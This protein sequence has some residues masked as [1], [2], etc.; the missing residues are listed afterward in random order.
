MPLAS[1]IFASLGIAL[2]LSVSAAAAQERL[3]GYD[4]SNFGR[5]VLNNSQF[6][7]P[8]FEAAFGA[9]NNESIREYSP[10]SVFAQMGRAVGRLDIL[11]DVRMF[12]CTAFIISERHLLTNWHCVPGI[13]TAIPGTGTQIKEVRFVAGYTQQG[14]SEGTDIYVVNPRPVEFSK[15]LDYAVLEVE[16]N[17][18]AIYGKLDLTDRV[19]SNGDPYWIIGHPH[20]EAQ[21]ISREQCK[22]NS[23]AISDDRLLHTC[24]T[25]PGTSGSPVLDASLHKVAPLHPARPTKEPVHFATPLATMRPQPTPFPPS[26][27]CP[28]PPV[29]YPLARAA[30]P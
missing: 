18:S 29:P 20:G 13:T 24:D 4:A 26:L 6:G 11:T 8:Q 3:P 25:L 15:E 10:E 9:Y 12:P 22:A 27:T 2:G 19:P 16:G 17:P 21:R 30:P 14:V 5:V 28:H 23:P 1:K 7:G